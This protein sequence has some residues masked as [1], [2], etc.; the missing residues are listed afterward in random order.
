[1][2]TGTFFQ[3]LPTGYDKADPK[4]LEAALRLTGSELGVVDGYEVDALHATFS[5]LVSNLDNWKAPIRIAIPA[6]SLDIARRAAMFM[7]SGELKVE[8]VSG[9]RW[10]VVSA[11]GY[12]QATGA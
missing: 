8:A 5:Q 7:G 2:A 4:A 1:M 12:Y 6:G 10:A 9:D 11:P 3:V